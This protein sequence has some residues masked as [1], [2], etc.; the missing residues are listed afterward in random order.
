[1]QTCVMLCDQVPS[2]HPAAGFTP[3]LL[4]LR[5]K[6]FPTP[7]QPPLKFTPSYTPHSTAHSFV[8][9]GV[10]YTVQISSVQGSTQDSTKGE[11]PHEIMQ[12]GH[13]C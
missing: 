2:C 3:T 13:S 5:G 8:R 4:D 12:E 11:G 1:M 7:L 9:S 6:P 10:A